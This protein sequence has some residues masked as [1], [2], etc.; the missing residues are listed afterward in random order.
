MPTIALGVS[1][2]YSIGS[3]IYKAHQASKEAS[4][5]EAT[6]KQA[7]ADSTAAK[8]KG[9]TAA[10]DI[11]APYTQLGA[12]AAT[13]LG[14]GLGI[15]MT[16]PASGSSGTS[17]E[18]ETS[19][20]TAPPTGAQQDTANKI[21]TPTPPKTMADDTANKRGTLADVTGMGG[22][23]QG[24]TVQ[25]AA[26]DARASSYTK[27]RAPDGEEQDVP[28]ELVPHFMKLGAQKVA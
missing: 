23:T 2:A 22:D 14:S 5:A 10:Q 13:L 19:G 12:G 16:P 9:A 21:G 17:G 3:S 4:K 6:Q 1:T 28:D 24:A 18:D 7:I 15:P 11:Y 25:Q 20:G 8:E 27:L 26:S